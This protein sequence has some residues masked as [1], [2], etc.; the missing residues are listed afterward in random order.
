MRK[1]LIGLILFVSLLIVTSTAYAFT[2][3]IIESYHLPADTV[4]RGDMVVSSP[5][6]IVEG[7]VDGDLYVIGENVQIKGRI[8]GDLLVFATTTI[9]SG[10][11]DGDIRTL[12]DTLFV[13]GKVGGSVTNMSHV[14]ILDR[15]GS[16]G[17]N[18]LTFTTNVDL[19]GKIAREANGR[20]DNVRITGSIG[21]GI[22][23]MYSRTMHIDA[24]AVIGG[25]LVYTSP[26]RAV[27]SPGVTF[28]GEERFTLEPAEESDDG[29]SYIPILLGL[30][31][32]SSTLLLWLAIRFLFPAGLT[33]VY[34]QL[35]Q[36][37]GSIVAWGTCL[38]LGVP[39]L[40]LLLLITVVGIPVSITLMLTHLILTWTAKVFVGSWIGIRLAE[41]FQW[42]V[43][44]FLAELLGVVALQCLLIIPLFGWLLA[45][46]VWIAFFGALVGSVHQANKTFHA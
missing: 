6:V 16:I 23:L 31:S 41:R 29:F 34:R 32:L 40:S 27:I 8:T 13:N 43:S 36:R 4:H 30:S 18:L 25:D 14:L 19:N 12:T 5:K 9:V 33:C 20:V 45:L 37:K 28:K 2:G 26:Q 21:E 11:I 10:E 17:K 7:V 22:S 38:V 42:K 35:D 15:D 1:K 39:V 44:P 24:P 46:P 3:I